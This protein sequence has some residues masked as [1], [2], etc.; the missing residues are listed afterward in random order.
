MYHRKRAALAKYRGPARKRRNT[1]ARPYQG[2]V[3][4]YQGYQPR[5]FSRGEWK[6]LDTTIS[7]AADTTGNMT[8]LNGMVPGNSASQRVGMKIDI[9]SIEYRLVARATATTGLDQGHRLLFLLDRQCNGVAPAALTDFLTVGNYQGMRN[10]AQRKR[11]KVLK[12]Y[13]LALNASG[14]A[15]SHRNIYKYMKFRRPIT[16]EYNAGTAGTIADIST[17]SLYFISIGNNVAGTTA[18]QVVGYV[19]IRYTDV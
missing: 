13:Y 11:F 4:S 14:E 15:G 6:Y 10:L 7:V 12:D 2:L 5:S 16:T 18:G 9:R 1:S 19:R 3:P 17:N 8:L